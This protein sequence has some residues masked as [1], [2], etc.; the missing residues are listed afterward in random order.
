MYIYIYL[1]VSIYR[2]MS[3][4]TISGISSNPFRIGRRG[5]SRCTK[6]WIHN[7]C[8]WN[9]SEPFPHMHADV[10]NVSYHI[11]VYTCILYNVPRCTGYTTRR[12]VGILNKYTGRWTTLHIMH[13]Y[14][15]H[16]ISPFTHYKKSNNKW[17]DLFPSLC[18][19]AINPFV[20]H[21]LQKIRTFCYQRAEEVRVM[22]CHGMPLW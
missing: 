5:Y 17:L 15:Y 8:L 3:G 21:N 11:Y 14:I 13:T 16:L 12:M 22:M 4:H 20:K 10:V 6:Q 18:C 7:I 19:V 9:T 1:R 2:D